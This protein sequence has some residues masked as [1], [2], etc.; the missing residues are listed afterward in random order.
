MMLSPKHLATQL[1]VCTTD[2]TEANFNAEQFRE[3][4]ALSHKLF[5]KDDSIGLM[6]PA[7]IVW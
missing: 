2:Y 5:L 6:Y 3:T 7:C 4:Q 1:S